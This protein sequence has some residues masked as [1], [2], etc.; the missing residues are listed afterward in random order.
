MSGSL[1]VSGKYV[2]VLFG[3]TLYQFSAEDLTELKRVK[4]EV[5]MPAFPPPPPGPAGEEGGEGQE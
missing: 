4:L 3:N 1:V 5:E 2:Y